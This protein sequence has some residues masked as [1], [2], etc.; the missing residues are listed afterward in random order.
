MK[1]MNVS[2]KVTFSYANLVILKML[3][4]YVF[5]L[6]VCTHLCHNTNTWFIRVCRFYIKEN[7][8]SGGLD[9]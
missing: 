3:Y 2:L 4:Q 1:I 8:L 6:K 9:A 5:S 7:P